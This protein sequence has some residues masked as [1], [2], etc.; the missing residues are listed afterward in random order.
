MIC[1]LN[2]ISN[3]IIV[4]NPNRRGTDSVDSQTQSETASVVQ[5]LE[6]HEGGQPLPKEKEYTIWWLQLPKT[7]GVY[8]YYL[9]TLKENSKF[10]SSALVAVEEKT[11]LSERKK[12][13]K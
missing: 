1:A 5:W 7:A 4:T 3:N 11:R 13:A 2:Y 9:L 6:L 8:R 10:S 12:K